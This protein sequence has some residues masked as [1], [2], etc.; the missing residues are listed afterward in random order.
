MVILQ[1]I[2]LVVK[3]RIDDI[4]YPKIKSVIQ[5]ASEEMTKSKVADLHYCSKVWG[6]SDDHDHEGR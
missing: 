6:Q 3:S 1:T 2:E 4:S 5:L